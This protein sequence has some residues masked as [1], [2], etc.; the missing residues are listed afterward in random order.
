MQICDIKYILKNNDSSEF[1]QN[2]MNLCCMC[3]VNTGCP[4]ICLIILISPKPQFLPF[5]F[6]RF[7][8]N[9]S[10]FTLSFPVFCPPWNGLMASYHCSY[11]ILSL[12]ENLSSPSLLAEIF[13][14]LL[15]FHQKAYLTPSTFFNNCFSGDLSELTRCCS[16]PN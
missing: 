4:K 12:L 6:F 7:N 1:K 16:I 10:L 14:I 3:H 13:F 8:V 5:F 11:D 2:L 9:L 15:T